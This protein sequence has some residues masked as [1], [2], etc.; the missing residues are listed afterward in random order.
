M[1]ARLI[2][3]LFAY[4][5]KSS[6]LPRIPFEAS[7]RVWACLNGI[8]PIWPIYEIACFREGVNKKNLLVLNMSTIFFFLF[9]SLNIQSKLRHE[10][11]Y[12]IAKL[13]LSKIIRFQTILI[14]IQKKLEKHLYF[15]K[16][17]A[18]SIFF[19]GFP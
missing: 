15:V 19:C 12:F 10:T 9:K 18:K 1:L 6:L 16:V 2:T 7:P 4:Y 5:I 17:S 11:T 13:W 14:C 8:W 3:D